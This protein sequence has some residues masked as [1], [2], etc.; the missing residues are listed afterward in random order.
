MTVLNVPKHPVEYLESVKDQL[1]NLN[2]LKV[3]FINM[4]LRQTAMP[5]TPPEG[6]LILGAILRQH[7]AV[8]SL[9]DLNAYRIKDDQATR[10]GLPNGRHLTVEEAEQLL[11][12][13][14]SR[15]GDQDIIAFSG[16]ITTLRWQEAMAKIVRKHQP[17]TF[18]VSGNGLATEL[19][20]GLFQWIPDL[21]GIAHSEGD[22]VMLAIALDAAAI[23]QMGSTQAY[24]SNKL[25]PYLLGEVQDRLRFL[26]AGN[27]PNDLDAL[28]YGAL[29]LLEQDPDGRNLLEEVYIPTP[30]WGA[31]ANNSSAAPF[32]MQRSLTTVSSRGCP[33]GCSFC[34]R[35]AQGER[36]WGVRSGKHLAGQVQQMIERYGIDFVGHSDDNFAVTPKRITDIRDAY[37]EMGVKIRWGTHTRMDEADERIIPM[38]EAGCIYIGFGAESASDPVLRRMNKGG[39]ILK[40]GLE[41]ITV[42]GRPYHVPATM[43][44]AVRNC[45]DH[46]IHANCTWIMAYPGETLEDLKTSVAFMQWQLTE[47]TRGLTPGSTEYRI[48]A[49]AVNRRMFVATAY[50]GTG[51]FKDPQA[52]G[53]L[54][55]V[56][57][58]QFDEQGEPVCNDALHQYVLELDD[59]TKL[60]HGPDGRPL[61]FSAMPDDVFQAARNLVDAGRTEAI[62]D[63]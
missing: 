35:G 52:R 48:A 50:P 23:K 14:L 3:T 1:R 45:R 55:R 29:D 16:M 15:S 44:M 32:T 42:D 30:V 6:P 28:P 7:G 20:Q 63:L 12:R 40:R 36:L 22:D 19:R 34:F 59:A 43:T 21:D 10:Q 4:P 61:N 49:D 39:F 33:Y 17:A 27:R 46:G 56:F 58:I 8:V 31:A 13:H 26:Y 47:M 60:L 25:S 18:L 62:L 57:G 9:L 41:P 37:A 24:L 5:N 51:M 2:G 53:D 11:L 54:T 38:A